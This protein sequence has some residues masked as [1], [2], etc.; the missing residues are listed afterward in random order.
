MTVLK[1]ALAP[2]N[3]VVPL[4]TV[5]PPSKVPP[6]AK[7]TPPVLAKLPVVATS[8]AASKLTA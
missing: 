2:D 8:G 5:R 4:V 1:V 7:V 3:V 6:A